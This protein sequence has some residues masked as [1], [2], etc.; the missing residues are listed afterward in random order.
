VCWNHSA[1]D[2]ERHG[3]SN[4]SVTVF[5]SVESFDKYWGQI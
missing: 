3:K 2:C 5:T 4:K 1:S